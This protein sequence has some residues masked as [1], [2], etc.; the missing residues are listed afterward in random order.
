MN[1]GAANYSQST[2]RVKAVAAPRCKDEFRANPTRAG[3]QY[4]QS[5]RP[6]TAQC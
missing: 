5:I 4:Q 6:L 2:I 1:D 3:V